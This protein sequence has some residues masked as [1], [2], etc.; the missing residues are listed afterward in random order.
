MTIT[1]ETEVTI[2]CAK[3]GNEL[4]G[5]A[6]Q[7]RREYVI[8]VEF[9]PSCSKAIQD[10]IDDKDSEISDLENQIQKLEDEKEALQ[11]AL[12]YKT[13]ENGK[14]CSSNNDKKDE[15]TQT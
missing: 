9:C 11:I 15:S 1:P 7:H 8:T 2:K 10:E 5:D 12:T 3:C 13:L 14:R 6:N 4:D